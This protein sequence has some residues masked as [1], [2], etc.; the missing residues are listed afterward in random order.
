VVEA[1]GIAGGIGSVSQRAGFAIAVAEISKQART[2]AMRMS[3]RS[4]GKPREKA[5]DLPVTSGEEFYVLRQ[6]LNDL[7][8]LDG[9]ILSPICK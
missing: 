6:T 1:A 9:W 7:A 8:G 5:S 3:D 4:C 2:T